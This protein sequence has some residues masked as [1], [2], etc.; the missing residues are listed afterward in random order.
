VRYPILLSILLLSSTTPLLTSCGG[1]G[2]PSDDGD[3]AHSAALHQLLQTDLAGIA[4]YSD[5][6]AV[7]LDQLSVSQ[8]TDEDPSKPALPIFSTVFGGTSGSDLMNYLN[9]RIQYYF[10]KYELKDA[11]YSAGQL[12]YKNWLT[13]DIVNT[14]LF[15]GLFPSGA[16]SEDSDSGAS[17]EIAA[18]NIGISYWMVGA[19]NNT[20]LS[21]SVGDQ[22]IVMNSPQNGIMEFGPGYTADLPDFYRQSILIHE[23]RH[24]DCTGGLSEQQI[25]KIRKEPNNAAFSQSRDAGE[26]GHLHV[27]CPT[28]EYQ[29]LAACDDERYGA[30]GVQEV[31]VHA[32]ALSAMN[33]GDEDS[34]EQTEEEELDTLSRLLVTTGQPDMSSDNAPGTAGE[35]AHPTL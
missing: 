25:E 14:R 23:A 16:S 29:G 3:D 33:S 30:Y 6:G 12:D 17:I 13:S 7:V 19:V 27:V 2:K 31:F 35:K 9:S 1:D 10:S 28:G 21:I 11:T 5:T 24:S 4:N 26:C 20:V 32:A 34:I 8:A 18:T 22:N 15:A